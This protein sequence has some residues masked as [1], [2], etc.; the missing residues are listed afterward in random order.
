MGDALPLLKAR[1][2]RAFTDGHVAVLLRAA[3]SQVDVPTRSAY[4]MAVVT[5]P[6]RA[7][8]AILRPCRAAL[9]RR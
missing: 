4:V 1:A 2:L 7:A 6:E 8:A 3:L 9:L 5:P